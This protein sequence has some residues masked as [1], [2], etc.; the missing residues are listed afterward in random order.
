MSAQLQGL[1]SSTEQAV[2]AL[3]PTGNAATRLQVSLQEG[4]TLAASSGAAILQNLHAEAVVR[5]DED[6]AGCIV[7]LECTSTP[8]AS[9][10][11]LAIGKVNHR[12]T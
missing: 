9:F 6:T 3:Q 11:E 1:V 7:G 4:R 5:P 2:K 8:P 10:L 12:C